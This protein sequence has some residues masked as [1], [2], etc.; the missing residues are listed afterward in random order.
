MW[1]ASS[2]RTHW[3]HV[4]ALVRVERPE[5]ADGERRGRAEAGPGGDVG[6]AHDLDARLDA[7]HAE[8]FADERVRD[9]VDARRPARA[10]ST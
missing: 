1:H 5:Q 7:V 2:A 6:E 8:R 3:R 9:V 10:P 4:L